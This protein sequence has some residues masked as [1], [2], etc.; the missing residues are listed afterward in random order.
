MRIDWT[1]LDDRRFEQLCHEL[2]LLSLPLEARA[3]Y[4]PSTVLFRADRQRDGTLASAPF[5]KLQPPVFFSFKTS[6]PGAIRGAS[7]AITAEF[8]RSERL[9]ILLADKPRSI[10]L[11]ANHDITEGDR[12]RI[13]EKIGGAA[14][15]W[16]VGRSQLEQRLQQHPFLLSRYF[17]WSELVECVHSEDVATLWKIL[18]ASGGALA[19]AVPH[20]GLLHPSLA[21][22]QALGRRLRILGG[23][24][25]GK[26]FF[27]YQLL[28]QL[29]PSLVLVLRSLDRDEILAP[30]R[31]IA[32]WAE[33]PLVI[34]VDNLHRSLTPTASCDA[35]P[36]LFESRDL[37]SKVSATFITYW[38]SV[39][40]KVEA[41]VPS[42]AWRQ[43]GFSEICLDDPP[44]GFIRGVVDAACSHLGIRADEAIRDAFV[45][46]VVDCEN[47]PACAV[48]AVAPYTGKVLD[49]ALGFYPIEIRERE[50]DWHHLF[51]DV[52]SNDPV[53]KSVLRT[54]AILR[55]SGLSR[56]LPELVMLL[57][58][59]LQGLP[60]GEVTGALERLQS[61]R[62]LRLDR[63]GV[64]GHDLQ[65]APRT[66]QLYDEQGPALFLRQ[67]AAHLKASMLSEFAEL[68]R[69]VLHGLGHLFWQA[70]DIDTCEKLNALLVEEHPK[71]QR[72]R[73]HLG[74][75]RIR[76]G[77]VNEGLIELRAAI[78]VQPELRH[79]SLYLRQ[80]LRHGRVEAAVA[81]LDEL[82]ARRPTDADTIAF[83]AHG[84][85]NVR[86]PR[87][88]LP[89]A[90]RVAK[91]LPDDPCSPALLAE[92]LWL[93]GGRRK[94]ARRTLDSGL[95]R[96][97]TDGHLLGV[98]AIFDLQEGLA[99]S[100]LE[101]ASAA[102]EA[103]PNEVR[104]HSLVAI[105][106]FQ[107]DRFEEA[108]NTVE[109]GRRLFSEWP[110]LL[111]VEGLLLLEGEKVSA[112]GR[113]L[114]QA[115]EHQ[116]ASSAASCGRASSRHSVGSP[117][118]RARGR[119][120]LA[121]VRRGS[122][123]RGSGPS[124]RS[125]ASR[126]A[127]RARRSFC[128]DFEL[129]DYLSR[130]DAEAQVWVSLGRLS[131]ERE[132]TRVRRGDAASLQAGFE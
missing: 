77:Q 83:L 58:M 110:E 5:E 25:S 108:R 44:R 8:I 66:V 47:T 115:L 63:E 51:E 127:R 19:T 27:V 94:Q 114:R 37:T 64:Y 13:R 23:P 105:L 109:L 111:A 93:S 81:S 3:L 91:V 103:Q 4:Q 14:E 119:K 22:A 124:Y 41:R 130:Q 38:T 89:W 82:A 55:A 117:S 2:V 33:L 54:L 78:S 9:Q 95:E 15:V 49:S 73:A 42:T 71:D 26:S 101:A 116:A 20:D 102:L 121:A 57:L 99:E 107:L 1:K 87:K 76:Q 61:R 53:A 122:L 12:R 31:D 65:L 46:S 59:E 52:T 18:P 21:D 60:A 48:A 132:D 128:R 118:W 113:C 43:W 36:L 17:S 75:C 97:P 80:C 70:G 11:F 112:A 68:R 40:L 125:P 28:K 104:N 6:D 16:I 126:R 79:V 74:L 92:L 32:A 56:P 35:F 50:L 69:A 62:W 131:L 123:S 67:F 45:D 84:Y 106:Q 30:I 72:A 96:W 100:A 34:L 98:K 88:G 39:R 7:K 86:E 29:P 129:E 24:G 120:P 85:A 90:R 10:V